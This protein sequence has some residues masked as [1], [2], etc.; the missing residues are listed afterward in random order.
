M[1]T[2]HVR[3]VR[4]AAEIVG[5]VEELAAQLGVRDKSMR[6]WMEGQLAVPQAIFLRC[7]DIVNAHQLDEL[8]GPNLN[9]SVPKYP[10]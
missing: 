7:V 4:R 6:K 10:T 3:T 5:G 2:V 1:P 8:S 9:N